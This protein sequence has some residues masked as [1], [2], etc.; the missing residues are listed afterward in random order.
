VGAIADSLADELAEE[1]LDA[2]RRV[3]MGSGAPRRGLSVSAQTPVDLLG[4]YV[5]LPMAVDEQPGRSFIDSR[6]LSGV[7]SVGGS[8]LPT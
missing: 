7:R 6:S 2:H 5:F 4:A 3:R 8:S 1:L